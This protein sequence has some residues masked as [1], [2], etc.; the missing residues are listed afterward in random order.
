MAAVLEPRSVEE[1]LLGAV[2]VEVDDPLDREGVVG[3]EGLEDGL[4]GV[5]VEEGADDVGVIAA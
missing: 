1:H 5:E 4:S 2:A 3:F